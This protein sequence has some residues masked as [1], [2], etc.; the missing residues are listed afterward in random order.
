MNISL[1]FAAFGAVFLAELIGDKTLYTI[2]VLAMRFRPVPIFSGFGVAFMLKMLAA[3]LI[4]GVIAHLPPALVAGITAATFFLM[5]VFIWLKTT[6]E[7]QEI[8]VSQSWSH[9]ALAAFASI[10]FTEWGDVG[11][12]TAATLSAYSHQPFIVWIGATLAM[13]T[14]GVIAMTLGMGLRKRIP[15][16]VFRY[17]AF[18]MCIVLGVLAIL[19]ID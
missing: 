3:V 1:L 13:M 19:R 9:G 18:G 14:K 4:G 8:Q 2:S 12:V 10:F 5:A 17:G 6:K 16:N 11:Q 15:R 7:P